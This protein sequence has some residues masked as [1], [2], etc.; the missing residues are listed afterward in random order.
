MKSASPVGD[1]DF[2]SLICLQYIYGVVDFLPQ[3]RE[4]NV[5]RKGKGGRYGVF[6]AKRRKMWYIEERKQVASI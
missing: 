2:V 6:V 3:R 5:N 1:A 4:K